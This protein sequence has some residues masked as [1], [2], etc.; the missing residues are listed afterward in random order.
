MKEISD[1]KIC[2]YL[3]NFSKLRRDYKFGGAPHKPIL[4]LAIINLIKKRNH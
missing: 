3:K 4:L 1:N 2:L